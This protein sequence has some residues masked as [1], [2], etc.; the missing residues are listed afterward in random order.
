MKKRWTVGIGGAVMG[1]LLVLS[2]ADGARMDEARKGKIMKTDAEWRELLTPEQYRVLRRK[3]TERPGTGEYLKHKEKGA[4]VCAGCGSELF[5]SASKYDSGCGWPSFSAAD[6]V[7]K[8][9]EEEDRSLGTARTEILC[10]SCQG[11]LGHVFND[12]P[13]PSGLRYCINSA[14]LDFDKHGEKGNTE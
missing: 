6:G 3:A 9:A 11:H 7:G 1:V 5:T 14:S 10:D 12:G 8:V 13:Q 2:F 4:Y